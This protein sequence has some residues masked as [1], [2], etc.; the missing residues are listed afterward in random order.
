[1]VL[2][3]GLGCTRLARAASLGE[4]GAEVVLGRKR[5]NLKRVILEDVT[6]T[7]KT[8]ELEDHAMHSVFTGSAYGVVQLGEWD[9]ANTFV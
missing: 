2:L 1:M 9:I 5:E 6:V 7:H 4:V 3:S 8:T